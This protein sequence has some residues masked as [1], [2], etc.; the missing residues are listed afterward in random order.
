MKDLKIDIGYLG[1]LFIAFTLPFSVL[2]NDV[3]IIVASLPVAIG[4]IANRSFRKMIITNIKSNKIALLFLAFAAFYVISG[5]IHWANYSQISILGADLEKRIV[6]LLFPLTLAIVPELT[7]GQIKN[8]F[9]TFFLGILLSSIILL[10]S[11]S[12]VSLVT[13]SLINLHPKYGMKENNFMYHRLGSYLDLHAVYYSCMVL[14]AFIM[15][16]VFARYHVVLVKKQER[17]IIILVLGYLLI[18]LFL[19][20]SATILIGLIIVISFY[21]FFHLY[22]ARKALGIIRISIVMSV[23]ILLLFAFGYRVVQKFG[24][25]GNFLTYDFAEPGGGQWNVLNLRKAKWDIASEAISDHWV[26]GVGPGNIHR[27][28]DTYYKKHN[29]TFALTQHYNP[30][31][32]PLDTFLTLGIIGFILLV[33]I[34]LM[35]F[36]DALKKNDMIWLMYMIGFTLFSLSESTLAVN[37]GIIF[38]TFFTIMLSYLPNRVSDYIQ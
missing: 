29:F 17:V 4:L 32:Q 3:A 19:L 9:W 21:A 28:L 25:R 34:Y 22:K 13:H 20:K 24:N 2:L 6:F 33:F 38:F 7:D 18:L 16:M 15:A 30:H 12:Y 14:M 35:A 1:I 37:K 8:V 36:Y 26:I 31:N 23:M 5:F 27:V 10:V 11:A